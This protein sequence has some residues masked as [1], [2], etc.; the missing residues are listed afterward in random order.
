M[1][2]QFRVLWPVLD[3]DMTV[4]ALQREALED[5]H[6]MLFEQGLRQIGPVAWS[7]AELPQLHLQAVLDVESWTDPE[8]GG[9]R[10]Q[11]WRVAP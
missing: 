10:R 5:L 11:P 8:R 6:D 4:P 2:A 3:L 1:T 7:L 9:A